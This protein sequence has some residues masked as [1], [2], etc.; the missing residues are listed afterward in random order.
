MTDRESAALLRNRG[1]GIIPPEQYVVDMEDR[2]QNI[3]ESVSAYTMTGLERGYSL[4]KAV[5]YICKNRLPGDFVECGVWKGGSSMLMALSLLEFNDTSRIL[6]LYDTYAGMTEPTAED[7][8]AWNDKSVTQKLQ[9]D[10]SVGKDSFS[11]WSVAKEEVEANMNATAYPE[12]KIRYIEGDVAET[13][14]TDVPERLALLRLDT[15]W[16]K[17]TAYELEIL[18]PK[19]VP[20]GI[21]VVDDYGHFKGAR[22]AVDEYFSK[23]ETFPL[24]CRADYTGRIMVKP[25]NPAKTDA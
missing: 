9:E 23:T 2:F 6:R 1:W 8:I 18:Y 22:K 15:D 12:E 13:L 5:E 11:T 19:V 3:W 20:G 14:A 24:F 16:Y 10:R 7:V 25:E 4:Y 21:V 17:S